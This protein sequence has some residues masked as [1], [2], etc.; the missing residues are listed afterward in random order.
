[1]SWE[2]WLEN[3]GYTKPN[4]NTYD[5]LIELAVSS[6][7]LDIKTRKSIICDRRQ[8]VIKWW[9]SNRDKFSHYNSYEKVAKMF[10]KG[11]DHSMIVHYLGKR[12]PTHNYKKNIECVR[13]FIES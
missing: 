3:N 7:D 12:K 6:Y 10:Y 2:G 8:F 1:M 13:D 11:F 9:Y 4:H 5:R